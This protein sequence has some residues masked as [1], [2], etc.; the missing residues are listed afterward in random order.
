MVLL[1]Q[2]ERCSFD[3]QAWN[4]FMKGLQTDLWSCCLPRDCRRIYAGVLKVALSHFA[5]RY[6]RVQPSRR[7]SAQFVCVFGVVYLFDS[8]LLLEDFVYSM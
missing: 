5:W 8:E 2:G 1:V 6:T 7:R 3:I 4:M